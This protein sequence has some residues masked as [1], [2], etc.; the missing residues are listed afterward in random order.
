MFILTNFLDFLV[1]FNLFRS[2][3]S[4]LYDYRFSKAYGII[5]TESLSGSCNL[6][7]FLYVRRLWKIQMANKKKMT[8]PP[9]KMRKMRFECGKMIVLK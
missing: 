3:T 5:R 8:C 4:H 2:Q 1:I 9:I 6:K 7:S